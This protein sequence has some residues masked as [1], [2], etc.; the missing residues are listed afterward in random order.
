M[1]MALL[2]CAM[3]VFGCAE[4]QEST[5]GYTLIKGT[6]TIDSDD[7]EV[8]FSGI[9]LYALG[10]SGSNDMD[11]L[12]F[13]QTNA[14]GWFESVVKVPDR[15]IYPVFVTR[16]NRVLHLTNFVFAAGDTITVSGT[17]PEL[18]RSFRAQSHENRAMDNYERIQ[19]LYTRAATLAYSGRVEAD[20]IPGLITQWSDI[21]WSLNEEYP[22][23]FASQLASIDAIEI[24]DGW[25]EDLMLE[26]LQK[27]DGSAI[28]LP[29][30]MIY[31]AE[32]KARRD[33]IDA[34]VSYLNALQ[35]D[36]KSRDERISLEMR[37]IE[38][39]TEFGE[40]D[41]AVRELKTIKDRNRDDIE[42][43]NWADAVE[44]QILNLLPGS[45]I[46][47][48]SVVLTDKE[49]ISRESL[50]GNYYL[51]EIV[52][53]A[54]ENYQGNYPELLNLGKVAARNGIKFYSIPL[55]N[56]QITVNAFFEEREKAWTFADAGVFDISDIANVLRVEQVPTRYLVNPEGVIINRYF[57][58]NIERLKADIQSIID[59]N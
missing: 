56:N 19:R 45:M 1:L 18:N 42:L 17:I 30:K 14:D 24:L 43:V 59:S 12:F 50:R 2:T 13:A 20:S 26:K 28:F 25:N 29:V 27:L 55:E 4:A 34:A 6:I 52:L 11:T 5:Q 41:R 16:N 51:L 44:Y 48:F 10:G 57:T 46:P 21:F 38:I 40:Y 58:H 33:G 37:R 8:D 49:V 47:D 3:F 9:T 36:A 15:G 53:L 23:T 22:N 35:R 39:L 31:G 7:P 32:I 54:D